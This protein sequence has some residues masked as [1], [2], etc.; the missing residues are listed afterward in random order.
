M[1]GMDWIELAQDRD[2]WRASANTVSKLW[3]RTR[4]YDTVP[5]EFSRL[6]E[7]LFSFSRRTLLRG[8]SLVRSVRQLFGY[9]N[10]QSNEVAFSRNIY[11]YRDLLSLLDLYL[12]ERIF[13]LV[14]ELAC[15]SERN[16][17]I[18]GHPYRRDFERGGG[19]KE[20]PWPSKFGF[21]SGSDILA[22]SKL[23]FLTALA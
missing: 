6:S 8:V 4:R 14:R 3:V 20:I 15:T 12:V 13:V 16:K 17:D 19:K 5:G 11:F 18:Q 22:Q 9:G 10:V 23:S 1:W 2:S 7:E 21:G